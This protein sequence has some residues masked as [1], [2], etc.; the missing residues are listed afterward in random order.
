MKKRYESLD[1]LRGLTVTFMCMVNNPGSWSHMFAPMRHAGWTG[2]TPTDLVYPF[3][4]FCM[5]VAM[6]FSFSKFE[7][8]TGR[9]IVKVLTR[10]AGIFAVGFLLNLYPFFPTDHGHLVFDW[11]RWCEW[12]AGKR[13]FG[14]LQ[15]IA[16]AYLIAGILALLLKKPK[17]IALSVVILCV[18]YTGVLLIWGTEPGPFTLEGTVSRKI[19]VALLGEAHVYHGYH[20][21]DGSAAAFD[22]EGPL[23]ALTAAASCLIG[24]LIGCLVKQNN[25]KPVDSVCQIFLFGMLSLGLAEL[26]SIWIPISKPLWSASYVFYASGWA[27]LAFAALIYVADVCRAGV[28]FTPFKVM[29]SNALLAFILSGVFA[30]SYQFVGFVPSKIFGATEL[31]SFAYSCIFA[32]TIFVILFVFYKKKIYIKL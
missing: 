26:I 27:M 14:V 11:D 10:S 29:G 20:F 17:R 13:I 9:G 6:A 16:C 1:I 22:P 19:D 18:V 21:A 2:C 4:I 7:D 8:Y 31:A 30:K 12:F 28:L 24:Y 5:G 23:G 3:F 32:F 25:N 15:R